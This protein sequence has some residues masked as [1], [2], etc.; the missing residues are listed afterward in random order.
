[1]RQ[2][3]ADK[4]SE[5]EQSG[6]A[7]LERAILETESDEELVELLRAHGVEAELS[8]LA[9]AEESGELSEED[10]EDVSGGCLVKKWISKYKKGFEDGRRDRDPD[11]EGIFY[12][13]GYVKGR[14]KRRK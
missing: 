5:L 3:I 12:S 6:D 7:A 8:D 13:L 9:D 1:M 2:E 14:R 10:L 4:L 11:Q